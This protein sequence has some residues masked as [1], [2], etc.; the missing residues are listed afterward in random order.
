MA[1]NSAE[2]SSD[3]I[4][5]AAGRA[6]RAFREGQDAER[7]RREQARA[8][9]PRTA[10]ADG[11]RATGLRE[12][13]V[14]AAAQ[15]AER[16][17]PLKE[18]V[19]HAAGE[20][21]RSFKENQAQDAA[22]LRGVREQVRADD[23]AARAER[24]AERERALDARDETE[25]GRVHPLLR[26][27]R[28][29]WLAVSLLLLGLATAFV[30]NGVRAD[31]DGGEVI[32]P[33]TGLQSIGPLGGATGQYTVGGVLAA[34]ALVTLWGWVGLLRRRRASLGTLTTVAVLLAIPAVL[35]PNPLFIVLGAAMAIGAVLLWLP[36]VRSRVR[37]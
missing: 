3:R 4:A 18:R 30:Y 23:D 12:R 8:E 21:G 31:R 22:R 35:R 32:D 34:L 13:A 37:R 11:S 33:V 10:D 19:G 5:R 2:N 24:Q 6:A 9:A 25:A 28:L 1:D 36:P 7:I 15:A 26:L 14:R 17:E 20:A 16:A 29:W 27:T